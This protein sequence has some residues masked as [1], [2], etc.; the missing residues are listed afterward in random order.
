MALLTLNV[1][2]AYGFMIDDS[3]KEKDKKV[4]RTTG[5][6]PTAQNRTTHSRDGRR[7][8]QGEDPQKS[9]GGM[10]ECMHWHISTASEERE[11]EKESGSNTESE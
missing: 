10:N 7:R 5:A 4:G 2:L 1:W 8:G 11:K 3:V 9:T 6:I